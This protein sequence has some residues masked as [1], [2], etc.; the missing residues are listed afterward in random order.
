MPDPWELVATLRQSGTDCVVVTVTSVRGSTPGSL[1]SKAV[2]TSDGLV[3]GNLGG[4]RVE[5]KAI[6]TA[7]TMLR[8]ARQV[9]IEHCWN[10]QRDVGMTCGGEMG[11]LFERIVASPPWHILI[12]GA[13]HVSQALVR[14]LSTLACRMDVVDV[15]SEWLEKLPD[16]DKVTRRQVGCFEEGVRWLTPETYLI[17][18]TKGHATDRPVLC[19][20]LNKHPDLPFVGVIGSA[21]KRAVLLSELKED[22]LNQEARDLIRCPVGLP[23]GSNDPAEIAISIAAQMLGEFR[24]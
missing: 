24:S 8:E 17:S 6:E 13:G 7:E 22:G 2:V 11:F 23:I 10:L 4:G 1:G 18:M 15:R 21:S 5:A 14:V 3:A 12:F 20:A 9:V 19:E 16:S